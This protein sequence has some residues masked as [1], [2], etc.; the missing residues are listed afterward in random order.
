[1][2]RLGIAQQKIARAQDI[3]QQTVSD[4]V[5]LNM[6]K[7][8]VAMKDY[9]AARKKLESRRLTYD[10]TLSRMQKTKKEDAKLEEELRAATA[11]YEETSDDVH[12]RM[13]S[14]REAEQASLL[15][16]IKLVEAEAEYFSQAQSIMLCLQQSLS[17]QSEHRIMKN[18]SLSASVPTTA[19]RSLKPSRIMSQ[20]HM[21]M[22]SLLSTNDEDGRVM[23]RRLRP[24]VGTAYTGTD[25]GSQLS[26]CGP[27]FTDDSKRRN[28]TGGVPSGTLEIP[29]RVVANFAFSAENANE[30]S[31]QPG[32]V[33]AVLDET[34]EGWWEGRILDAQGNL[35]S[36]KG[37]FPANYCS[38]CT[39]LVIENE[40]RKEIL[41][42]PI[43]QAAITEFTVK[44]AGRGRP[45]PPPVPKK[46]GSAFQ[47]ISSLSEP[48]H[49]Y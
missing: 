32:D 10:S 29:R 26:V 15:D 19:D 46:K 24:S 49:N 1:M 44:A 22:P 9:Q 36:R 23:A 18:S 3:F 12:T 14:I 2:N 21:S 39:A 27:Q 43:R 7:S 40:H 28:L 35:S 4:A 38:P 42:H 20:S 13:I 41:S 31:L 11:R 48:L 34:T 8:L 30:I 17:T 25:T 16:L 37:L 6:E 47:R 33:V 45:P 5:I